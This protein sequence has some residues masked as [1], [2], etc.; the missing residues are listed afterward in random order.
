[1]ERRA[2][3]LRQTHETQIE[4]SLNL[5]G[6]GT[7][8]IATGVPFFDHML[9]QIAVHGL[10]DLTIHATGDVQVDDHHTVE[11]VGIVL[12]Q[13]LQQALGDRK[14]LT[15]YGTATIPL[16]E[17]LAQV[18]LDLSGRSFLA[19]EIDWPQPLA[20]RFDVELVE[21]FLRA[22][23]THAGLTLHV[24]L[25]AARNSHHAAEAIFKALGRALCQAATVDPRRSGVPSSKGVL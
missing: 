17:A 7:H 22:L 13:A 5:D 1:M 20:G 9:T 18:V 10:I 12:G 24:R 4:L 6:E 11:D 25:L 15:R 21:E 8:D 14:G 19:C 16:D 2:E 23:A 3:V